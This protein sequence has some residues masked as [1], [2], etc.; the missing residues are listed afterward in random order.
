VILGAIGDDFTGSSD[1]A[2]TLAKSGMDTVQYC[3]LPDSPVYPN[4][5]AGVIAIKIRLIPAA[6]AVAQYLAAPEW[7]R[8]QGCQQIVFKNFSTFDST[9]AGNIC[10]VAEALAR[11]VLCQ[12]HGYRLSEDAV[13]QACDETCG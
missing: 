8:A 5:E 12:R 2:N 6:D 9:D 1:A 10:P 11:E 7:L 13:D 4:V 3:G